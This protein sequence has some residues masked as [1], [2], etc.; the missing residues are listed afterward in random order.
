M[1][2]AAGASWYPDSVAP[3]CPR[4]LQCNIGSQGLGNQLENAVFCLDVARKLGVA[5]VSSGFQTSTGHLESGHG[6]DIKSVAED[7]LG[8]HFRH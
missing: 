2:F 8:L 7:L 3:Q 1:L 5:I 4:F 6:N